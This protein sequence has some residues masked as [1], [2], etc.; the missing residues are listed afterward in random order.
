M[1]YTYV[2]AIVTYSHALSMNKIVRQTM[3]FWRE[4]ELQFVTVIG[5][6]AVATLSFF[7][8]SMHGQKWQQEPLVITRAEGPPT[9]VLEQSTDSRG[10]VAG[11]AQHNALQVTG[12][13]VVNETAA[14]CAYVGSKNS[15]KYY[16]PTCSFAKRVKPE[17]LRCFTSDEDALKKG[18]VRSKGC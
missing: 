12:E 11:A 7:L 5:F 1:L 16:P 18:Y 9:I 13:V 10:E 4:H 8:G 15:N 2:E 14:E 3:D 17:N 6:I